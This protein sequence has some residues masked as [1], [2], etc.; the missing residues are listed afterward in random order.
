MVEII[1]SESS[2]LIH[3]E[4]GLLFQKPNMVSF[5]ANAGVDTSNVDENENMVT[6]LPI[7]SNG[8]GI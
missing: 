8:P 4:N 3:L 5:C 7:D 2:E 6:L 1:L